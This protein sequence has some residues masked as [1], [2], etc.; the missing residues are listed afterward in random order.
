[1]RD[2]HVKGCRRCTAILKA[3]QRLSYKRLGRHERRQ[4][5]SAAAPKEAPTPI[6][7]PDPSAAAQTA[8]MRAVASLEAF[9]LTRVKPERVRMMAGEDDALLE[10]L[11]RKY[12]VVLLARGRSLE[13]RSSAATGRSWRAGGR[14]AGSCTWTRRARRRC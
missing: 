12:A 4:L 8:T 5:L 10:R 3:S 2:A 6:H 14:S 1:M 7:P 11:G 13:R 9:G